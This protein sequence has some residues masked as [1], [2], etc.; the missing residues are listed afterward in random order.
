[1]FLIRPILMGPA[2]HMFGCRL[3]TGTVLEPS[4]SGSTHFYH[5]QLEH[6][7][8]QESVLT[9]AALSQF[10]KHCARRLSC[11][12][13]SFCPSVALSLFVQLACARL[14]ICVS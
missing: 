9:F 13:L 2:V 8:E 6:L 11:K 5:G 3:L 1:M 10:R 7:R 4:V 12:A 14:S